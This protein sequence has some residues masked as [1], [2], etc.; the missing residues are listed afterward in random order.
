MI[1][2]KHKRKLPKRLYIIRHAKSLPNLRLTEAEAAGAEHFELPMP[3]HLAPIVPEGHAQ[4]ADLAAWF[5][6]L[7]S[8]EQPSKIVSSTHTRTRETS[9][10]IVTGSGL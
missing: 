6:S 10:G 3:E 8:D 7:P 5:A 9:A 2:K 4:V 1:K